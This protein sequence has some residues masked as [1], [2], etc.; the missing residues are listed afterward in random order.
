MELIQPWGELSVG[1]EGRHL[2]QDFSKNSLTFES[3]IS[4]YVTKNISVFCG[5]ESVMIHDQLYLPKGDVS[6]EDLL[7]ERRKLATTY[8]MSGQIGLR[9]TFG[10]IYNNLVN[11]R[12]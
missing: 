9:F 10:S 4:M 3:D 2:F 11:E 6:L 12:F 8:E 1:L 7:F 5:F